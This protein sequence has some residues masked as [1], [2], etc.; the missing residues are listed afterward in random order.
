MRPRGWGEKR[1]KRRSRG[2]P[3]ARCG[4]SCLQSQLL[5]R[6]REEDFH[7][8]ANPCKVR[9]FQSQNLNANKR[10]RGVAWVQP[11]DPPP[12]REEEFPLDG[13]TSQASYTLP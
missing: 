5:G 11:Q 7:L 8:E 13:H 3:R 4:G 6:L 2:T 9:D 1:R 10:G 12:Q